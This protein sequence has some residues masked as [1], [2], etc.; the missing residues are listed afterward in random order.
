MER[1]DGPGKRLLMNKIMRHAVLAHQLVLSVIVK[2]KK[3]RSSAMAETPLLQS[4]ISIK[5]IT[6]NDG[7]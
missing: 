3:L 7:G 5:I 1:T 6:E 4:N 2:Q